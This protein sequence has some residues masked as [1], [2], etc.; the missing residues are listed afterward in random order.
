MYWRRWWRWHGRQSTLLQDRQ[1][2]TDEHRNCMCMRQYHE[3]RQQPY[4]P[5][6]CR[7]CWSE[8]LA[9]TVPRCRLENV[10]LQPTRWGLWTYYNENTSHRFFILNFFIA[11][12]CVWTFYNDLYCEN[13]QYSDWLSSEWQRWRQLVRL[14]MCMWRIMEL[15]RCYQQ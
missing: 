12:V 8:R 7:M 14:A 6:H 15:T 1:P 10:Q 3:Y 13:W 11:G 9:C 5:W 4:L 2:T